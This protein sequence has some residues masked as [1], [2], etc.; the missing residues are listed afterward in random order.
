[1]NYKDDSLKAVIFFIVFAALMLLWVS[2]QK[3]DKSYL[4]NP[5]LPDEGNGGCV[6]SPSGDCL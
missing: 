3:E 1:M 4:H 2:F 6:V 5:Y